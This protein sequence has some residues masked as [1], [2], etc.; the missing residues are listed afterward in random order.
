MPHDNARARVAELIARL[1]RHPNA[2]EIQ[3]LL[4]TAR[5][6]QRALDASHM[7]GIRFR[8]FS[9]TRLIA[10]PGA[11]VGDEERRLIG[12]IKASLEAAGLPLKH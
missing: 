12:E 9:L 10:Q 8:A 7:E 1:E 6:L 11:A 2:G 4:D 5:Q 3:T